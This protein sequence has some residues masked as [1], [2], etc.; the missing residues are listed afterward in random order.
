MNR[1]YA[2]KISLWSVCCHSD[3]EVSGP[4]QSTHF[5]AC[6]AANGPQ[7]YKNYYLCM[8]SSYTSAVITILTT[9]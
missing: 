8:L 2:N 3:L 6:V 1:L 7:T 9:N 4:P 5:L